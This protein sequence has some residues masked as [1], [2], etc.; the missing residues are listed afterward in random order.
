MT[1]R[2]LIATWAVLAVAMPLNGALREFGFKRIVSQA[3]A[4]T[5]SVVSGIAVILLV[6]RLMF[7]IPAATPTRQL[8]LYSVI[9]VALTVAYEFGI[10]IAGGRSWPE[11]L[12][13]YALWKGRL[14]PLVLAALALTPFLWRP[15]RS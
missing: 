3:T 1:Y 6:T 10:G 9:L 7:R 15:G 14:W 11:M 8:A 12:E 2:R 4:E 13:N 5:L